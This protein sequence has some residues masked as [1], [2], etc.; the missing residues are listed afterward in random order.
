MVKRTEQELI[1]DLCEFFHMGKHMKCLHKFAIGEKGVYVKIPSGIK[2]E[3]IW[4]LLDKISVKSKEDIKL[5]LADTQQEL[6][7]D[8]EDIDLLQQFV[9]K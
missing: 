1:E 6:G 8:I 3:T 2:S 4:I 9:T 5:V 7:R